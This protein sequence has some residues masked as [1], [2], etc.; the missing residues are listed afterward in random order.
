MSGAIAAALKKIAA[1]VGTNKKTWKTV[2]GIALGIVVIICM[3]IAAVLGIFTGGLNLEKDRWQELI[4]EQRTIGQAICKDIDDKMTETGYSRL[5]I[6]EA[7]LLYEYGLFGYGGEEGFTKKFVACFEKEQ[8]D[9]EL[10][11]A[12]NETFGTNIQTEEYRNLVYELREEYAKK[13]QGE[14]D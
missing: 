7:L 4:E 8:T 10:I 11:A 9:E 12:V 2:G 5:R 13:E 1:Y 6:E 3:P 14:A